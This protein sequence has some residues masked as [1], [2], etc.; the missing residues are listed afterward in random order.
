[1]TKQN[2]LTISVPHSEIEHL[3]KLMS[4]IQ[5]P[6]VTYNTEET[7]PMANQAVR[8][9][10]RYALEAWEILHKWIGG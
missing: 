2:E 5:S 8:L 10:S 4:K 1:M 7:L 3:I 9:S 6:D